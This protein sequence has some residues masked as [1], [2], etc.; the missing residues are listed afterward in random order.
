MNHSESLLQASIVQWLQ[1]NGFYFFSVPNE[2][3]AKKSMPFLKAMGLRSGVSDLVVILPLGKICF[4]E[5]KSQVGTQSEPQKRFQR[6]VEELGHKYFVVRDLEEVG[7]ILN[8]I[9]I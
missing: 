1:D 2:G 6:R 9:N 3:H 4:L 8:D 5:V 7:L